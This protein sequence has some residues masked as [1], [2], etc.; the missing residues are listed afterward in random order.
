M[1]FGANL[2][3]LGRHLRY[4]AYQALIQLLIYSINKLTYAFQGI[5]S[6]FLRALFLQRGR[7]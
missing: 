7:Y 3:L 6:R 5:W 1:F 4:P 2:L